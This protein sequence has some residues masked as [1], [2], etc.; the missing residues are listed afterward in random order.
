[1]WEKGWW[2]VAGG[3]GHVRVLE[4]SPLNL[5]QIIIKELR[6][7]L[8]VAK[9]LDHLA[10]GHAVH[11]KGV[12]VIVDPDERPADPH[13]PLRDDGCVAQV[14]HEGQERGESVS[15]SEAPCESHGCESEL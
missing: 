10:I 14:S 9:E 8:F 1:M 3:R 6:L 2:L 13:P 12:A 11:K 15:C 5:F 4:I 7:V